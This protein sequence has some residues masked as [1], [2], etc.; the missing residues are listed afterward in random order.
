[1]NID[2]FVDSYNINEIPN[3]I[4]NKLKLLEYLQYF[5]WYYTQEMILNDNDLMDYLAETKWGHIE[6]K[7]NKNF[8]NIATLN[9]VKKLLDNKSYKKNIKSLG[10]PYELRGT[11]RSLGGSIANAFFEKISLLPKKYFKDD[12]NKKD[13]FIYE[14]VSEDD[15]KIYFSHTF[16][17]MKS[18]KELMLLYNN[19]IKDIKDYYINNLNIDTKNAEKYSEIAIKYIILYDVNYR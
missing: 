7:Y 14:L 6:I 15:A 9:N 10:V 11:I 1:M 2:G 18:D 12:I 13:V 3:L 8:K 4:T 5:F 16:E 19:A 17:K